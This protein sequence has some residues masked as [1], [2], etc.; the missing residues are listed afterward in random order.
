M[1]QI[2]ANQIF[3]YLYS[4]QNNFEMT[5]K[6]YFPKTFELNLWKIKMNFI[7]FLQNF[8]YKL[9][10]FSI[11]ISMINNNNLKNGILFF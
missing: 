7:K 2:F 5:R 3:F 1:L 9:L 10:I 6:K 8:H 4:T 11:A